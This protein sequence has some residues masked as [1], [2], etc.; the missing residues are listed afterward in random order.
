MVTHGITGFFYKYFFTC[1]I[2]LFAICG[3]VVAR[4]AIIVSGSWGMF[5]GWKFICTVLLEERHHI[6]MAIYLG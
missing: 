4:V 2:G 5:C 1:V 3:T 6:R